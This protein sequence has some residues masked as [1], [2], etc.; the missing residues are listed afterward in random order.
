VIEADIKIQRN[1]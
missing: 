1:V